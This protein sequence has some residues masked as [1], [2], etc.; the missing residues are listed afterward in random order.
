[1]SESRVAAGKED[2][3][4]RALGSISRAGSGGVTRLRPFVKLNNPNRHI[5]LRISALSLSFGVVIL[6]RLDSDDG[7]PTTL[8]TPLFLGAHFKEDLRILND[9]NGEGE[10][11]VI[12]ICLEPEAGVAVVRRWLRLA[13]GGREV[14]DGLCKERVVVQAHEV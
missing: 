12:W 3:S 7:A 11:L 14:G 1:M 6:E 5:T 8:V 9:D 4:S 2:N 13:D 10:T